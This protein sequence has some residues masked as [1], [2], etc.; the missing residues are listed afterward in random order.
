MKDCLFYAHKL[1]LKAQAPDLTEL[2]E[3]FDKSNPMPFTD[4]EPSVFETMLKHLYRKNINP[5]KWADKPS[6]L[7][8]L[9]S[10]GKND[11]TSFRPDLETWYVDYLKSHG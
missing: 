5:E 1:I 11:F 2:C 4:V 8:I 10:A 3:A 7:D 9:I 6:M